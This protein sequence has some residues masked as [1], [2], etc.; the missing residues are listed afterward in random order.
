MNREESARVETGGRD[1]PG[2]E[3][4][5]KLAGV[6]HLPRG[7]VAILRDLGVSQEKIAAYDLRFPTPTSMRRGRRPLASRMRR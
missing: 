1:G 5:L 2:N 6:G 3:Q 7:S 4:G